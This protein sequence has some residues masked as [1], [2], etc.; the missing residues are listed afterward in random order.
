M[1]LVKLQGGLGNQMFQYAC[2]RALSVRLGIPLLLDISFFEAVHDRTFS[3]NQFNI[4]AR[5]A[6]EDEITKAKSPLQ[7][8]LDFFRAHKRVVIEKGAGFDPKVLLTPDK[9]Y[10]DGY[11]QSEKYFLPITNKLL[12]EF[13]LKAPFS[14]YAADFARLVGDSNSVSI[15]IR[16]GDY[17]ANPKFAAVHGTLPLAYYEEAMGLIEQKVDNPRYFLFSDDPEWAEE[18]IRSRHKIDLVS[19]GSATEGEELSLMALCQHH[20]IANSS[21]SWWGAWLN[22]KAGKVV[23]APKQWFVDPNR[24]IPDLIPETWIQ[25]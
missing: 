15:H 24:S 5:I 25:L 23:I 20:I 18:H 11:W 17:V 14:S 3:L 22:K 8:A 6:L 13:S 9:A 10:L 1:I 4:Q 16:R 19:G 7:K 12:S 21:F 2:G